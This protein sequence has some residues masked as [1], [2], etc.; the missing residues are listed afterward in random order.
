MLNV[1]NKHNISDTLVQALDTSVNEISTITNSHCTELAKFRDN[2]TIDQQ[3]VNAELKV[4]TEGVQEQQKEI[5]NL[6]EKVD[7]LDIRLTTNIDESRK[8]L[9]ESMVDSKNDLKAGLER[10]ESLFGM[11]MTRFDSPSNLQCVTNAPINSI[12]TAHINQQKSSFSIESADQRL[13]RQHHHFS[14]EHHTG[15]TQACIKRSHEPTNNV[16][17]HSIPFSIPNNTVSSP[18]RSPKKKRQNTQYSNEGDIADALSK[19]I[20]ADDVS[21]DSPV[22][23]TRLITDPTDLYTNGYHSLRERIIDSTSPRTPPTDNY[24]ESHDP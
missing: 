1:E 19:P 4:V 22:H 23:N 11:I 12:H 9:K 15:E 8:E 21:M 24:D 7:Q 16:I 2:Y 18:S 6:D 3:S 10:M 17:S 14:N 5:Q 13:E 20:A